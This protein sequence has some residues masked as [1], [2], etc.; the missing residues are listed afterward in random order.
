M[1][2]AL[3]VDAGA[4]VEILTLISVAKIYRKFSTRKNTYE[5]YRGRQ[6]Y[7]LLDNKYR[8]YDIKCKQDKQLLAGC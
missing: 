6:K 2:V 7:K 8:A 4:T 3:I 1:N 5:K